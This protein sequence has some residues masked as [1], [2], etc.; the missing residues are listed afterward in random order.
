MKPPDRFREAT[1]G[2]LQA[3]PAG[4]GPAVTQVVIVDDHRMMRDGLR[5]IVESSPSLAL[6]GE[7]ADVTAAWEVISATKPDLILMDLN[8]V[9]G[10]GVDLTRRVGAAYP[11]TKVLVLT[12]QN[13]PKSIKS[14]LE[15][16]ACGVLLKT[17][18]HDELAVA[19]ESVLAGERYLCRH[20]H[21]TLNAAPVPADDE[22]AML[23]G[24]GLTPRERQVLGL[25]VDG[26]RNKEI[27]VR[28]GIGTKAV[29]TYRSR[30]MK[31]LDCD[32]PAD[33]VRTAIR[34][35]LITP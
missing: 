17:N 12:G 9:G 7:A 4:S 34:L 19:I 32:S 14:A 35:K 29:E 13:E 24:T 30:L 25:V 28:L 22:A 16:G 8:L 2:D 18:G 5:R 3:V 20:S 33:L 26:L 27:A 23:L 11:T 15:A 10:N 6:A 31:R 1:T 21:A